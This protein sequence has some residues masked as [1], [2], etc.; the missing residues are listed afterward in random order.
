MVDKPLLPPVRSDILFRRVGDEWI[1][2]DPVADQLHSVNLA[3]AMVW[4]LLAD[5]ESR[6]SIESAIAEAFDGRA[7]G[8]PVGEAIEQFRRAGLLQ[9]DP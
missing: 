1:L 4:R 8:D 3:A 6:E 7:N 5:G 2:F 9:P